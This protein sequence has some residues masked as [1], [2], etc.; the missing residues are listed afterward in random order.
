MGSAELHELCANTGSG[1]IF[2]DKGTLCDDVDAVFADMH[3]GDRKRVRATGGKLTIEPHGNNQTWTVN[4]KLD[5]DC[6]ASIDFNVPGKPSPPPV[7]LAGQFWAMNTDKQSQRKLA[8]E[9]TDP[10][11]TI[12]SAHT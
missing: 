11:G 10:S 4:A 7:K 8:V 6:V 2:C 12:A 3:D 5:D 1:R 9:F